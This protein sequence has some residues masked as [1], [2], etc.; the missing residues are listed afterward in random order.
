MITFLV[1]YYYPGP[2]SMFNFKEVKARDFLGSCASD[3]DMILDWWFY[4]DTY[5]KDTK[6]VIPATLQYIHLFFTI[7]GTLSWIS[8]ASDGRAVDYCVIRPLRL[9]ECIFFSCG[10]CCK[11]KPPNSLRSIKPLGSSSSSN[12]VLPVTELW[13]ETKSENKWKLNS[14]RISTGFL[15]FCGILLEDIP[16]IILS[17]LVQEFKGE[18]ESMAAGLLIANMLTSIYNALIKLADA[19]DQKEDVVSVSERS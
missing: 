18:E 13:E 9:L 10:R 17:F 12:K 19:Y 2:R 14:V 7:L 11:P 6:N 15:L 3:I 5:I 4:A 8:L 1:Q 16:Q